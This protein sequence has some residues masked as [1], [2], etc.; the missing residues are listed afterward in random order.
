MLG[1]DP[2]LRWQAER[3]RAGAPPEAAQLLSRQ[4]ADG[5][6]AGGASFPREDV[7]GGEDADGDGRP[8]V[9]TTWSLNDLPEWGGEIDA[10]INGYTLANGAWLGADVSGPAQWFGDDRTAEGME[11]R[12]GGGLDPVVS[13]QGGGDGPAG[14]PLRARRGCR[15]PAAPRS[16]RPGRRSRRTA[17]R[18]CRSRG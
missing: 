10:C 11:L 4:G 6:W 7:L 15:S 9:A 8:W 17:R 13:F 2:A 14:R 1:S 16:C 12:V 5:Q 18:P 3:D